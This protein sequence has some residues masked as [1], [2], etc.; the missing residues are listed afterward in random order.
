MHLIKTEGMSEMNLR[1]RA[2]NPERDIPA[3]F[4]AMRKKGTQLPAKLLAGSAVAYAL[5]PVDL[6]PDFIPVV[7]YLDDIILLPI[8]I[9]AAIKLIPT[10]VFA[11]CQTESKYLWENGKPQK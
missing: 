2:K 11:Q 6:I 1:E 3:A 10:E 4:M 7:G 9:S 8:L 5:S